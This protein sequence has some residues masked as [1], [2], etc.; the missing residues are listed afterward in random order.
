MQ[1]ITPRRPDGERTEMWLDA[2]D[3]SEIARHVRTCDWE[4]AVTDQ[5]NGKRYL[6]RGA[7]CQLPGCNCDAVIV[8]EMLVVA[9]RQSNSASL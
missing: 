2:P 3:F 6:I 1:R 9:L 8:R 7:E 5:S 4:A